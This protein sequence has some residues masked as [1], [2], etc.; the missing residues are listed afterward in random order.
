MSHI[1]NYVNINFRSQNCDTLSSNTSKLA[2]NVIFASN[3][4]AIPIPVRILKEPSNE[5]AVTHQTYATLVN[6]CQLTDWYG[7]EET[8]FIPRIIPQNARLLYDAFHLA[9]IPQQAEVEM[10]KLDGMLTTLFSLAPLE[11]QNL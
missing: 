3:A 6:E 11:R 1:D 10:R 5:N 8:L 2:S 7:Y 9:K 4:K